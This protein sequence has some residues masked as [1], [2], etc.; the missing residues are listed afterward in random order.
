MT[1]LPGSPEPM[2]GPAPTPVP[3]RPWRLLDAPVHALAWIT[4][5]MLVF[6]IG[7]ATTLHFVHLRRI[8]RAHEEHMEI[9]ALSRTNH[10]TAYERQ[11]IIIERLD[12]LQADMDLA[13][14]RQRR[15]AEARAAKEDE[16]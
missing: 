7:W 1:S 2:P 13:L 12:R 6:A 10:L 3:S 16:P 14:S 11:S 15:E 8:E 9:M 4:I 5:G